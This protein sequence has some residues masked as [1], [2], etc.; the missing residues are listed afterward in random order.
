MDE[1]VPMRKRT[2]KLADKPNPG[3]P[4]AQD[5]GC[6]CPVM[7]NSYGQGYMGQPGIFVMIAS[8]PLHGTECADEVEV[9]DP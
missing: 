6:E 9:D 2:K 4:E 3:S 7:D 1:V 8:C 5:A